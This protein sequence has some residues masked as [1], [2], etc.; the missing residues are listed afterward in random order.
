[1]TQGS[2]PETPESI[3][4]AL[5]AAEAATDAAT[6]AQGLRS[7]AETALARL[8]RSTGRIGPLLIGCLVGSTAVLGLGALFHLRAMAD[9]RTATAAQIEA[10]AVFSTRVGTLDTHLAEVGAMTERLSAL[11][12]Q[13]AAITPGMEAGLANAIENLIGHA[14]AQ[15]ETA[16]N[17][18]SQTTT[19][20]L[21]AI[22]ANATQTTE[23][24]TSGASDLQLALSRMLATGLPATGGEVVN[25]A[26][27]PPAP[28]A[29]P[30]PRPAPTARPAAPPPSNPFSYP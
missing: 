13:T 15:A 16:Q 5:E 12:T 18:Q 4:L 1:M 10:L 9:L 24:V 30:A 14:T 17:V 22:A 7:A 8:D 19:A 29:A 11:E 20:L 26:P 28:P 21:D 23:A 25:R 6:E 2:T 27:A 3:R